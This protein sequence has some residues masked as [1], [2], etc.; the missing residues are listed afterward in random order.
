LNL[1]QVVEMKIGILSDTHNDSAA[2]RRALQEFRRHG[3]CTL[4]HCGD[5]T[6]ADMVAHFA[7]FEVY[8]VR[9]NMDRHHVP[10][11]TAAV[12]VQEGAHWLGKGDEVELLGKRIAIVHG[13]R[14]ELFE[15]LL[16]AEPDYVF[17]G[18]THRRRDERVGQTRIINPGALG[19]VKYEA[20]SICILDLGSDQLNVIQL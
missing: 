5:L 1:R 8:F 2:T 7:G 16:F 6:T 20:R 9:G 15:M 10:A 3:V 12:G 17:T 14:E 13:D 4:F 19:G 11:L 18:H